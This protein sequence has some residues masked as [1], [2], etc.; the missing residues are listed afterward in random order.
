[1]FVFNFCLFDYSV[2]W[3]VPPWVYP[4]WDSLC[5][6][7]LVDYF[8]SRVQEFFSYYFF[9]YFLRFFL[10]LFSFWGPYNENVGAFYIV[11]DISEA[12]FISFHPFFCILF[13]SSDFHHSVLRVTYLFCLSY[14]AVDSF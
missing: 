5:F 7:D 6:L 1:M 3:F 14:S 2:S 10:S 8:L 13:Y 12:V 11:L 9:K 4:S